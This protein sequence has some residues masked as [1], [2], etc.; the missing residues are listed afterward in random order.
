MSDAPETLYY[1]GAARLLAAD[2]VR[3]YR[4]SQPFRRREERLWRL[5]AGWL[6]RRLG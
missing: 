2:A 5:R 6:R 4:D 1:L 3:A